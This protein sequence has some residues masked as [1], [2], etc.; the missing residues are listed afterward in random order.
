M[1]RPTRRRDLAVALT[2]TLSLAAA[3]H[4]AN[5]REAPL[6]ALDH[7]ADIT[8]VYAFVSY[9]DPTRVTLIMNVDPLL[10]PANGPTYFPFDPEITYA[11]KVDNDQDA[12]EDVTYEF[13]FRTVQ[14]LPGV[15]TAF[16]GA[17]GGLASPPS[18]APPVPPGVVIV[19]PAIIA[20][21][22]PGALGL[23]QRQRYSITRI[24]G[25]GPTATRT[26]LATDLP[27]VPSNAG[28]RTM[29]DY[30][31]LFEQGIRSLADDTR[32]F[33]GTVD[34]PFWI[35]LGAAFDT[36]NL[37]PG[38]SAVGIAGVLGDEQDARDDVNFAADD[39]AGYNVN[40]IAVEVPIAALTR[41]G[42]RHDAT[43]PEAVIGVWATT[44][45]PR[46][47]ILPLAPGLPSRV[48]TS[49]AQIQRMGNPLINELLIGIGSKDAFSMRQPRDDAAFAPFLLDPV[50]AR[51]ASAAVFETLGSDAL[52][53]PPPP[54]N[55]LLPLVQYLAPIA[56]PGTPTGPIADLLRLNTGVP[57]TPVGQR[58]RL[59]LL[60][61]DQAG[62]P[63]G[64][65]VSDDVVDIALRVAVGGVLTGD[66]RFSG[67]PH[68]RLGDGVNTND[69]PYRETFPY[70]ASAHSGRDARHVDPGEPGCASPFDADLPVPCPID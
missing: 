44:S 12:V 20:I 6:T 57:P 53:V 25:T 19:P 3:A 51:V 13:R 42:R 22:G 55:D 11:I 15:F 52:P 61:G 64:R 16:V 60:T 70:V 67:F 68:N 26:V 2:T 50:I 47:K 69:R 9:D 37:R 40:S 63:N 23:G 45:R 62:F 33:A 56:P 30:E 65:R 4:A 36:L 24:D 41:D 35:D 49:T 38:A 39:V 31:S 8:D 18:S 54:R 48:S 34:D 32:V 58:S 66:T 21:D 1:P 29:P 14:T 5:H 27:T 43:E 17:G 59:G 10:E 7:K 28:P 46:V